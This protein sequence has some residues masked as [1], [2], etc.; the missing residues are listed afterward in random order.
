MKI[1]RLSVAA[2]AAVMILSVLS[3][4]G[5]VAAEEVDEEELS[6]EVEQNG[7]VLVT[8]TDEENATLENATVNVSVTDGADYEDAGEHKTDENGTVELTEPEETVDVTIE[9]THDDA[10]AETDVTLEA[11]E[12]DLELSIA[13]EQD[14][15]ALVTVTDNVTDEPVEA[16]VNVSTVEENASYDGTGE[17]ED[18]ENGTVELTEPEETVNVSITASYDNES[19]TTDVTL[20][21]AEDQ[22]VEENDI[23]GNMVS[24]FVASLEPSEHDGGIGAQVSSFVLENNPGNAPDGVG[25]GEQGPPEDVGSDNETEQG[26]PEDVNPGGNG[27]QDDDSSGGSA[28]NGNSGGQGPPNN[29]GPGGN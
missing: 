4:L 14:G 27:G 9:A 22:I 29:A 10:S 1:S 8:V 2:L 28:G 19:V 17:Y 23:F 21:S 11:A 6:I 24:S 12:D 16:T 3:P 5:A 13:V 20:K 15:D 25:P 26:P 18:V 7:D